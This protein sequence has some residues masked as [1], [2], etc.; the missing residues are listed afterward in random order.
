MLKV[1]LITDD[2]EA[3]VLTSFHLQRQ[4][5]V[6]K[7][8]VLNPPSYCLEGFAEEGFDCVVVDL[9]LPP[10]RCW[11]VAEA[12]RCTPG[13][14]D[15]PMVV[16]LWSTIDTERLQRLDPYVWVTKPYPMWELLE[17][18]EQAGGSSLSRAVFVDPS[19]KR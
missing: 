1:L 5:H 17:A 14:E 13:L 12:I 8:R 3:A 16:S 9:S 2:I 7:R 4:G 11:Q 15:V 18:V 6:V 10:P 19:P